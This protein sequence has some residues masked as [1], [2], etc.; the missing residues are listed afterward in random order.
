[1]QARAAGQIAQF[2]LEGGRE[3]EVFRTGMRIDGAPLTVE[4]GP[5]ELGQDTDAVLSEIGLDESD[6]RALREAGAI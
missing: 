1:M 3:A 4:T 5:P 6:I 2:E